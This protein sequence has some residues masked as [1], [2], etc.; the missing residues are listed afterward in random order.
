M[1][2]NMTGFRWFSKILAFLFLCAKVASILEGLKM[3]SSGRDSS[4]QLR[5]NAMPAG[6]TASVVSRSNAKQSEGLTFASH[7]NSI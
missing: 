5:I 3:S 4:E 2:T 6:P 7:E 1:N